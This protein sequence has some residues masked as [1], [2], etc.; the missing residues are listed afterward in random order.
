[1]RHALCHE[2]EVWYGCSNKVHCCTARGGG[3]GREE[4]G[5]DGSVQRRRRLAQTG[6]QL[7]SGIVVSR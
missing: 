5:K 1:M 4:R 3:G 7:A 6:A 2:R